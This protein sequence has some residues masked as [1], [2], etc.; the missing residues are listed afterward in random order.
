MNNW[1]GLPIRNDILSGRCRFPGG[2]DTAPRSFIERVVRE[3]NDDLA[4]AVNVRIDNVT[5]YLFA[6]TDKEDW[7]VDD[8]PNQAPPFETMWFE[9]QAPSGIRSSRPR[10]DIGKRADQILDG[11]ARIDPSSVFWGILYKAIR[12][13]DDP[14]D[15]RWEAHMTYFRRDPSG[16]MGPLAM[17]RQLIGEDGTPLHAG[18][19]MIDSAFAEMLGRGAFP[20]EDPNRVAADMVSP[21]FFPAKL[22]ISFMHCKNVKSSE[23][24]PSRQARRA[25]ERKGEPTIR[26]HVLD[27]LPMRTVLETEGGS[28][29]VGLQRAL[30]ICRGHFSNY[31]EE[32]PL[33]GKYAGRFWVPSHVRG[34]ADAGVAMKDYRVNS[35]KDAA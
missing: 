3:M 25:S 34:S 35:P 6:G 16:C 14:P 12:R 28:G 1:L 8:F 29:S 9:S 23:V 7:G 18:Q 11:G 26:Y 13:E 15:S 19:V 20:G 10:H 5:E 21:F 4:V 24:L 17:W 22:A 33:F 32:R 2:Y 27:I 30:H 31:T